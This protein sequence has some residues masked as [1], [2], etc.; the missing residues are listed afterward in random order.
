MAVKGLALCQFVLRLAITGK[1]DY[2]VKKGEE[3][4]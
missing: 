3:G 2:G 1:H 4:S